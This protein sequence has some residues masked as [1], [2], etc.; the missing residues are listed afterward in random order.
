MGKDI[1]KE[2]KME[3][4]RETRKSAGCSQPITI[5]PMPHLFGKRKNKDAVHLISFHSLIDVFIIKK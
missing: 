5:Q 4:R 1:R 3:M 2:T